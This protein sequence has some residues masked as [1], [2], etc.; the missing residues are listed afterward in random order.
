MFYD[1]NKQKRYN[2][3]ENVYKKQNRSKPMTK[4]ALVSDIHGN[5][6]AFEAVVNDIKQQN[7][8][9]TW[10]LGDLVLPG[11]AGNVIFELLAD[12]NTTVKLRGNWDDVFLKV[13]DNPEAYNLDDP[14]DIYMGSLAQYLSTRL[15]ERY[16][17]ELRQA[18]IEKLITRNN[19]KISL[20]HNE[21]DHNGGPNLFPAADTDNFDKLFKDSSVDVAIY[22]HTHHQVF[23]YSHQDQLVLNPGSVGEPFFKHP[24][25]NQDRRAQYTILEIDDTGILAINFRKVSYDL[26]LEYARAKASAVPYADLYNRLL[27][28]GI[29]PTQ[30]KELLAKHNEKDGYNEQFK[31]YLTKLK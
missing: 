29:S 8:S 25:L 30:D 12:I 6:T 19:L 22:A 2:I 23:R 13:L 17:D 24:P 9:E 5:L 31:T 1:I 15:D 16:V 4:I 18:P 3:L 28:Q 14:S 21:L 10:F 26:E 7:I 20:S 11:P 27:T